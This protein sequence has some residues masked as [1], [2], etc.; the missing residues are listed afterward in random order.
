[1]VVRQVRQI[2]LVLAGARFDLEFSR[3]EA[4][5][6]LAFRHLAPQLWIGQTDPVCHNIWVVVQ[7]HILDGSTHP[8]T[9]PHPPQT[10]NDTTLVSGKAR[11]SYPTAPSRHPHFQPF[12]DHVADQRGDDQVQAA[13]QH[14]VLR[15]KR[16]L[17]HEAT[18]EQLIKTRDR[19]SFAHEPIEDLPQA[20]QP[21]IPQELVCRTYT[22]CQHPSRE[23]VLLTAVLAS[24]EPM[25]GQHGGSPRMPGG[26]H[27]KLH[28]GNRA[29]QREGAQDKR[30]H[31]G[32]NSCGPAATL[33]IINDMS[34]GHIGTASAR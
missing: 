28:E 13:L 25:F 24:L 7:S 1:M 6:R 8:P 16:E 30:G 11:P 31:P 12:Q 17:L 34:G 14:G 18:L 3:A 29:T 20:G 9:P 2:G 21:P 15:R 32:R 23:Q 26:V 5:N 22:H 10:I 4:T 33:D 19:S 27:T